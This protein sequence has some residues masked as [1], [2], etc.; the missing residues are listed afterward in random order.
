LC[1]K[2]ITPNKLGQVANFHNALPDENANQLYLVLEIQE[3]VKTP[4]ATIN[5]LNTGL[6]FPPINIFF[7]TI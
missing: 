1:N 3:D 5:A 7:L 6:S 4:R 2:K